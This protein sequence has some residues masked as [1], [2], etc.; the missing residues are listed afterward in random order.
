MDFNENFQQGMKYFQEKEYEKALDYLNAALAINP[1][2]VGIK[3]LIENAKESKELEAEMDQALNN[4]IKHRLNFIGIT[5]V[6]NVNID[7]VERIITKSINTLN[8]KPNDVSAKEYLVEVYYIRG[9]IFMSKKEYVRA[10]EDFSEAINYYPDCV[11]AYMKR[12]QLCLEIEDYEQAIKDREKLLQ[13]SPEDERKKKKRIATVYVA[14]GISLDRKG[15]FK[16]AINDFEMCL[17]YDPDDDTARE[18]LKLSKASLD[19]KWQAEEEERKRK[20]RER[21]EWLASKEGKKW[22]LE[23]NKRIKRDERIKN[24]KISSKKSKMVLIILSFFALDRFYTGCIKLGIFKILSFGLFGIGFIW[25][26]VDIILA[27]L[28]MQKDKNGY[29][30]NRY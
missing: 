8:F 24:S 19:K 15:E 28:G 2:N 11:I 23:E 29:S 30:I 10:I 18:I 25:A 12:S 13:I 1:D 17:K 5:G 4:E 14:R 21:Q 3:K 20:E 6:N 27:I 22:Q 26:I 16:N 9:M 7:D